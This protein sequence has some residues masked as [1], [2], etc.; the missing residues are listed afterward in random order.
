MAVDAALARRRGLVTRRPPVLASA[1]TLREDQ[2]ASDRFQRGKR[3]F[4]VG[5]HQP[6]ITN[7]IGGQDRRQPTFC[8]IRHCSTSPRPDAPVSFA[9]LRSYQIT[10]RKYGA[11]HSAA[12]VP[13][14]G[15]LLAFAGTTVSRGPTGKSGLW[16][17]FTRRRRGGVK[18]PAPGW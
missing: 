14:L 7:D 4:L 18:S 17:A 12:V 13:A 6:R 15:G 8:A 3:A 10:R 1:N 5:V 9:H 11:C 2:F 16:V